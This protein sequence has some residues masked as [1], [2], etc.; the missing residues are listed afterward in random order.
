MRQCLMLL[1]SI[2]LG[3]NVAAAPLP[4]ELKGSKLEH[5][6]GKKYDPSDVCE[7]TLEGNTLRVVMPATVDVT[8]TA[9][10][11]TPR[12]T[13]E[14]EGD[15]VAEAVVSYIPPKNDDG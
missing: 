3:L 8:A 2:L 6:F 12:T 5:L 11:G 13:R 4:K 15:F 9:L 10:K 14:V 7:Y 1:T